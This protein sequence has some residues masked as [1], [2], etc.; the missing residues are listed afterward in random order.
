MGY[1]QKIKSVLKCLLCIPV[2]LCAV[3]FSPLSFR[4]LTGFIPMKKCHLESGK[5]LS[6]DNSVDASLDL[7]SRSDVQTCTDWKA[8]IIWDGMFDPDLYDKTHQSE[9]SSVALTVFAVGRYLDA[10]LLTFLNSS[11]HHFMLGLP[12]TY[13]VFTDTPEKVP[14]IKLGPL[15]SIKVIKV[16]RHSRWQDISM[17]RMKTIAD[18]IESDI[19]H[20]CT[21][22]F[23]FDVDQV[24]TGRFGSEALGDSVA[25]LH[26][27]YYHLP[28]RLFTYDRNPK[29]KAYMESGDFYYHAAVFGGSWN[30]VKALTESCYHSIMEDKENNVEALWHDESHLNKYMWLQKPSRVLSPEYCW[31]TSIGDRNDIRVTRLLWATKHYDTLRTD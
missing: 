2:A 31:D 12:V 10:Y 19:R 26:A 20:H 3:Y 17:M 7:G 28:E 23:C 9:G 1:N 8:P 13:Y 5:M 30:S 11:E 29:S 4:F 6:L 18:V 15:R 27:H 14:D 16:K 21:H 25:L 22:V 24:F